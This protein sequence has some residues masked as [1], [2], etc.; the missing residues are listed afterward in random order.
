MVNVYSPNID[1]RSYGRNAILAVGWNFVRIGFDK[2]L[3]NDIIHGGIAFAAGAIGFLVGGPWGAGSV[4]A[5]A[6][7]L[8]RHLDSGSGWWFDYNIVL[9]T[10]TRF[11]RQ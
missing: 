6:V 4:A 7:V 2:G 1:V 3:V 8:D 10:V 11:G 9:G 5:V